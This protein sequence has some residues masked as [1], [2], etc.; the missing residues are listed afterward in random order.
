MNKKLIFVTILGCMC[1]TYTYTS[2]V[3]HPINY[4]LISKVIKVESNWNAKAVSSKGALGLGQIRYAVWHKE[5]KEKNIIKNR[6][7]LFDP[8]KNIIATKYIL[9]KYFIESK[10]DLRKTLTKYSG[11]AKNYYQ[12]V[13]NNE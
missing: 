6:K 2:K 8:Q 1:M 4:D 9:D 13:T 11:G 12:K 7:D 5:L 10:G 3:E